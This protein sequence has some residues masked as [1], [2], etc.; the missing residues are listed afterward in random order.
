[1]NRAYSGVF[2]S[3]NEM[4]REDNEEW[5]AEFD[6]IRWKFR[7]SVARKDQALAIRY[8]ESRLPSEALAEIEGQTPRYILNRLKFGDFLR[9]YKT[10]KSLD[11]PVDFSFSKFSKYWAQTSSRDDDLTRFEE[12]KDVEW[13]IRLLETSSER[14][15]RVTSDGIPEL[16]AGN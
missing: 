5:R 8:C 16:V 10:D 1:M 12:V 13:V 4:I 6:K 7:K 11:I 3:I 15:C 9:Y 2:V 14:G